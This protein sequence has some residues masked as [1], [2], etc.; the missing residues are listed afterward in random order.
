MQRWLTVALTLLSFAAVAQVQATPTLMQALPTSSRFRCLN[1][2]TIQDPS[3]AQAALNPF[4]RAF[5]D[6]ASHWDAKLA[7]SGADGDNCTNGFELSDEDGDGKLD[8]GRTEE[9]GNPGESGCA[10]QLST[11]TWQ[12]L[13][14]LF[15]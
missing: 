15:R 1:C 9:R 12:S 11:T 7:R 5:K 14:L 2:H 4:G 13:K 6:N 8:V 10:L 3:T